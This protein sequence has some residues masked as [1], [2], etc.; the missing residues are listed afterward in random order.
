MENRL[1]TDSKFFCK[2]IGLVYRSKNI[3]KND[4]KYTEQERT[5]AM[6]ALHLLDKWCMA[7]GIQA[8]GSFDGLYFEKWL[9]E[10][11]N[12]CCK[13]G[14]LEVALIHIGKVLFFC[15][16]DPCG[17]WI[18]K[19]AAEALNRK[20]VDE[21]RDGFRSAIFSARSVSWVDFTGKPERELAE[22]YRQQANEVENAGFQRLAVSLRGL[23][24]SY[25]R[26]ADRIIDEHKLKNEE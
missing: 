9:T 13:T 12:I 20:D 10:T 16:A 7:P 17:L 4:T 26:D 21:M 24:D 2:I 14:H 15:P 18:N 19:I 11:W 6:N 3:L 8:D 25:D 5:I 1:A 23:A 22:K